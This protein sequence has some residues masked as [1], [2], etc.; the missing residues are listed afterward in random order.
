M[1]DFYLSGLKENESKT[2]CFAIDQR[3]CVQR[4]SLILSI[5]ILLLHEKMNSFNTIASTKNQG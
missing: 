1:S 2:Q 5:I 3:C 4:N